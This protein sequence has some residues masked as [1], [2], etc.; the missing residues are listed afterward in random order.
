YS[1]VASTRN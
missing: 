1:L